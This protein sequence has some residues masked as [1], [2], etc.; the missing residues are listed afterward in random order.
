M[1]RA[2][3]LPGHEL[4]RRAEARLLPLLRHAMANVPFYRDYCDHNG[5]SP[6]ELRG[7]AD[8]QQF[9][10]LAKADYRQRSL[11]FFVAM[12]VPEHRRL[13]STTSGSTG[14]PFKFFLDREAIPLVLA[15]QFYLDETIGLY[16]FNRL[17][18]IAVPSSWSRVARGATE[19]ASLCTDPL[20]AAVGASIGP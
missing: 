5:I 17:V 20:Q 18:R 4:Q 6:S 15:T 11:G 7:V 14:E 9:P 3:W 13:L 10:V 1:K 8:L 19:S 12:N 16:P 2:Q